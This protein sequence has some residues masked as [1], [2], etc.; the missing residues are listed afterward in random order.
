[1]MKLSFSMKPAKKEVPIVKAPPPKPSLFSAAEEDDAADAP[2]PLAYKVEA[3]KAMQK[4]IEKEKAV[5]ST[6]YDYDEVW[7]RMQ[8]VKEKQKAA[9]AIEAVERKVGFYF[10]LFSRAAHCDL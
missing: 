6:V 1:M 10:E 5:D 2:P 4:R 7:E 3:S 8:E 9:K